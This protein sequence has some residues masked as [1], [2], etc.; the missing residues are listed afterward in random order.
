MPLPEDTVDTTTSTKKTTPTETNSEVN[1]VKS[2]SKSSK[3][4][5]EKKHRHSG[6]FD[7]ISSPKSEFK[8][9]LSD[10]NPE[11]KRAKRK[12][13]KLQ[14]QFQSTPDLLP[15][16]PL[17][18]SEDTSKKP[19]I[20]PNTTSA[21]ALMQLDYAQKQIVCLFFFQCLP[22]ITHLLNLPFN[23]PYL[24]VLSSFSKF[25]YILPN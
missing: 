3:T 13:Q 23:S 7:S 19:E 6:E 16:T 20:T 2:S 1:P 11:T 15:K 22:R 17:E 5:P 18:E 21:T 10:L 14:Q 9:F 12:S 24:F 25:G 8:Q 4:T